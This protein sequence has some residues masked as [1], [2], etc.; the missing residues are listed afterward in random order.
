MNLT[1]KQITSIIKEEIDYLLLEIKGDQSIITLGEESFNVVNV[2]GANMK[3]A[4]QR[5]KDRDE[6]G[7]QGIY[8]IKQGADAFD[9]A[10]NK[11]PESGKYYRA[12]VYVAFL[13]AEQSQRIG[14]DNFIPRDDLEAMDTA[15]EYSQSKV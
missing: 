8:I 5:S 6:F 3:L 9:A 10:M 2:A 11:L 4:Y 13:E 7:E 12:Y 1:K 15:I 14:E